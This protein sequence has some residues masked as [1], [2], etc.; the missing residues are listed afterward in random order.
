MNRINALRK[1]V[2][3]NL[4]MIDGTLNYDRVTDAITKLANTIAE[5]DTDESLWW[6]GESE[7]FTLADL[8]IGGY[9]FYSDYHNGQWSKEYA[10]LCALG[11][12]FKPNFTEL[13]NGS[14]E[15]EVYTILQH[16]FEQERA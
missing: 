13:E 2:T 9:W 7:A 5:T 4:T 14:P 1:V 15:F 10:A 16:L 8:I 6:L 11:E 3:Y 12:M